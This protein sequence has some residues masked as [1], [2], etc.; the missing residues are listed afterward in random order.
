MQVVTTTSSQV[1]PESVL[2]FARHFLSHSMCRG[3]PTE[4]N[5]PNVEFV[6]F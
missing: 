6:A 1:M 4:R 2:R 3:F 5:P